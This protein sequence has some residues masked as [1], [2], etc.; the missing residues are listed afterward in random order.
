MKKNTI[1][2]QILFFIFFISFIGCTNEPL[3]GEFVQEEENTVEEGQFKAN[4]ESNDFVTNATAAVLTTA[5]NT[6]TL[7]AVKNDTGETIILTVENPAE[8]TFNLTLGNPSFVNNGTYLDGV[9]NDN[10]YVSIFALGGSGQLQITEFDT[11]ANTVSGTFSFIA[12][13]ILLDA[14]GQPVIDGAGN[15]V[16][17]TR[18]ITVGEFNK[19]A[20][21]VDD[22]TGGEGNNQ[23]PNDVFLA[24]VD[25]EDFVSETLSVTQTTIGNVNMIN[26]IGEN[27][28]GQTLR[29]DFPQDLGVGTFAMEALSDG[30]KIIGL[31]NQNNGGENLTSNPGTLTITE[32][33]TGEGII[34]GFFEF[35]GTDPLNIDPTVVEITEGNF[36]LYGLDLSVEINSSFSADI[37]TVSFSPDEVSVTQ[38]T[39]NGVNRVSIIAKDTNTNQEIDLL[40]PKDITVGTY[41]LES[42][43]VN[44]EEKIGVYT[45]NTGSSETFKSTSGTLTITAY[46]LETDVIEGTFEFQAEDLTGNS[47]DVHQ[48]T[49]GEFLVEIQ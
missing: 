6:L 18:N 14:N 34:K 45:P 12:V 8:G 13:R 3:E 35:T 17:E 23:S 27:N 2:K 15:T 22:T 25:G 46:D 1:F 30:T 44:G 20:F 9:N 10:P 21:T 48:I 31:Y 4:V 7:T 5:N 37:N 28:L 47:T 16:T 40:F 43:L 39:F 32:Y 49:N 24:K 38:D 26:I 36:E 42:L 41:A 11:T 33:N 29:I 19:I